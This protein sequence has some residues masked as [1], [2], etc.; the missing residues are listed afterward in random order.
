MILRHPDGT[1]QY[2]TLTDI[3]Q[4][5]TIDKNIVQLA[6]SSLQSKLDQI[7]DLLPYGVFLV[8]L[9]LTPAI[10]LLIVAIYSVATWLAAAIGRKNLS[11]K[12]S[13]QIGLHTAT[14][15]ETAAFL[16]KL[17]F[18]DANLPSVYTLAFFGATLFAL[19]SIK[20]TTRHTNHGKHT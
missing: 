10:T 6:T 12:K 11:Y 18:P 7:I 15:A 17:V 8:V 14:F 3:S 2:F 20:S 9:F 1:K 4:D 13:F 19:Y 5:V 16:Q